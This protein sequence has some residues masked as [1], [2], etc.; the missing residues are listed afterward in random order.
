MDPSAGAVKTPVQS[1]TL[2]R[3]AFQLEPEVEAYV[4]A[5]SVGYGASGEA[6]VAETAALGDP[7]VMMLA[8]E[9][10]ALLRFLAGVLR[11]RRALDVGTFTGLSALAM[12][13]G[14]GPDGRV[15]SIDRHAP[16][17]DIARRHWQSAG[18]DDRIEVRLGEAMDLLRDLPS[19]EKFDLVFIDVDKA[20]LG[21]YLERSL[22]LLAPGGVIAIDNTLWHGWVLDDSHSDA[23]TRGV[24][25][26]NQR[27]A[28]DPALEV[29]LLPV[30][31]GL[32]LV[33][34]RT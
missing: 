4:L 18:V 24:R 22:E 7:A 25:E 15:V 1:W 5:H 17:V 32:T 27:M 33:R 14:M 28:V 34:R 31:D 21:R 12:A 30:G 8:K 20:G 3:M 13:D 11:C 26:V 16:W 29:V 6:L 23:D 9:E 2:G 19:D 10:Y